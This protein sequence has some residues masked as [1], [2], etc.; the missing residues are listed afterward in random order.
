[1]LAP[2]AGKSE[3]ENQGQR[4]VTGQR[5]MQSSSDIFWAGR[6]AKRPPFLCA[7]VARHE[8]VCADRR[9]N[10]HTNEAVRRAMR[11]YPRAC[12]CKIRGCGTD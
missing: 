8:N 5:L 2:Y 11:S 12:P 1:M 3:Y 4:I 10:D 7:A 6:K 9:R